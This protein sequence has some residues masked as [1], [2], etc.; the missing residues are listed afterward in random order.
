VGLPADTVDV[1]VHDDTLFVVVMKP[2]TIMQGATVR[3]E[4]AALRVGTKDDEGTETTL[5]DLEEVAAAWHLA[6]PKEGA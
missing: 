3:T 4:V 2:S 5:A 1:T 6:H